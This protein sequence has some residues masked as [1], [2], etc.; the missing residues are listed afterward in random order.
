MMTKAQQK[1]AEQAYKDAAQ[2]IGSK[3]KLA[4]ALGLEPS[5]LYQWKVVPSKHVLAIEKLTSV[6]RYKLR[7]DYY[8]K[9]ED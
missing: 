2:K 5:G 9:E 7:P 4:K 6:P 3:Y 1:I 8:P